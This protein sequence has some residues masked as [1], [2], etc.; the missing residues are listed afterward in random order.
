MIHTFIDLQDKCILV[1]GAS[2]GIGKTIV[3]AL[4]KN[5]SKIVFNYR[6][7]EEKAVKLQGQLLSLGAISATGIKFDLTD[8]DKYNHFTS[9][10][11]ISINNL[12]ELIDSIRKESNEIERSKVAFPYILARLEE[13]KTHSMEFGKHCGFFIDEGNYLTDSQIQSNIFGDF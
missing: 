10:G 2:R 6:G 5:R 9:A 7:D 8:Y 11:K 4:A 13:I 12:D 1:T 3:E